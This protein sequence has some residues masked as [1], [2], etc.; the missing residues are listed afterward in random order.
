ME[1]HIA[2]QQPTTFRHPI[3][4]PP[5]IWVEIFMLS[6]PTLDHAQAP[7]KA[8][9]ALVCRLWNAMIESSPT[10]WSGISIRDK[11]GYVQKSLLQSGESL[12]D[13]Y[14]VCPYTS[15]DTDC[16]SG[17]TCWQFMR[18]VH[19]HAQR[20][21]HAAVHVVSKKVD[22]PSGNLFPFL[23]S[24]DLYS[25][26]KLPTGEEY[27][28]FLNSSQ[29]PY[30]RALS[31]V[32]LPLDRWNISLSPNLSKLS[33]ATSLLS[34]SELLSILKNCPNLA[35]LNLGRFQ[36]NVEVVS[37]AEFAPTVELNALQ[38]F[39]LR[40]TSVSF[41]GNL[42]KGLRLPKD[43]TIALILRMN[44]RTMFASPW[45]TPLSHYHERFQ[46]FSRIDPIIITASAT[47]T[48]STQIVVG[49]YRW[50]VELWLPSSH[51]IKG[52]LEWFGINT[53][54][55]KGTS[56]FEPSPVDSVAPN[57]RPMVTLEFRT[58][59]HNEIQ[60]RN[61]LPILSLQCITKIKATS[62]RYFRPLADLISY[63]SKPQPVIQGSVATVSSV[64][65][66]DDGVTVRPSNAWSVPNLRELVVEV[67][68]S[69]E[70]WKAV[71]DVV[72]GRSGERVPSEV[73]G[74]PARLK[75]IEFISN[76]DDV[77]KMYEG[78]AGK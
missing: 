43:C 28:V 59:S 9:L 18:E 48:S 54:I 45:N 21:R 40:A 7:Q 50:N 66:E 34:S 37:G 62:F 39:K 47:S 61:I 68:D 75:R 5:E 11:L 25:T 46:P 14:G 78:A 30:L 15:L 12:I 76:S 63:L 58:Y 69:D 19:R 57:N 13:I 3:D 71:I 70:I 10:L 56:H 77:S 49:G 60:L 23:R 22:A 4:I 26:E 27:L 16:R 42:L 67:P 36:A 44:N 72:K 64:R 35:S 65:P 2:S 31:L 1:S 73:R 29:T 38:E 55:N 53:E 6:L 33:I 32:Y 17:G 20:W 8:A 24:L 41:A 52:A 74:Q 51:H